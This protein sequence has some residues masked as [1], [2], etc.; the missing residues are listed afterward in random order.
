MTELATGQKIR[1]CHPSVD[2]F[3]RYSP[4][5][6]PRFSYQARS[7]VVTLERVSTQWAIRRRSGSTRDRSRDLDLD[8][9]EDIIIRLSRPGKPTDNAFI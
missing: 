7:V 5:I 1:V 2:T 6:D 3:S 4:A 8:L 9:F